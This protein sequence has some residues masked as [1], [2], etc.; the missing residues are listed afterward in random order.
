M[1]SPEALRARL[2]TAWT[3]NRVDWLAGAGDWPLRLPI[4]PPNEA[5]A[6]ADWALFDGW[7]RSW[8]G[9]AHGRVQTVD[10]AWARLGR[11][12]LPDAWCFDSP[13]QVAEALE[14]GGRWRR[15]AARLADWRLR[16]DPQARFPRW[17][18]VLARSFDVLADLE[19][20]QF[21]R[22]GS[23]LDWLQRHPCSGLYPRQ[24][25]IEGIDS[26]WL[27]SW[28]RVLGSWLQALG[29]EVEGGSDFLALAGLRRPQERLR[30]RLLDPR[31]ATV[32]G[33]LADITAPLEEIVTLPLSPARALVV[34]NRDTGLA[35][36]PLP[37]T[38]AFMALGYSVDMLARI[39]WLAAVPLAYWGDIDTHGLAILDR[40]RHHL[41][42]A[43]SLLMDEATLLAFRHLCVVED[44]PA[45]MQPQRLTPEEA[46]LYRTLREHRHGAALRLEQ[47]RVPWGYAWQRIEQWAGVSTC[48]SDRTLQV[49]D[50]HDS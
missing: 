5:Q 14:Q 33:G 17:P 28:Q 21:E 6:A 35:L 41:P 42:Q 7:L 8:R 13:E 32:T 2:A 12:T 25:P 19:P 37:G 43:Q 45:L 50:R 22:L 49:A 34:E 23:A 27:A 44:R 31:L 11:Q 26:K 46:A 30:L 15:A 29:R 9:V 38:V 40:A 10:R 39:P 20:A 18:R 1:R 36:Q 16:F 3:R 47:E 48:G 24:L 4:L